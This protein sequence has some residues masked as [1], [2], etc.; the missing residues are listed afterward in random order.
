MR[1]NTRERLVARLAGWL[2]IPTRPGDFVKL[3]CW[4]RSVATSSG[5][6]ESMW[7]VLKQLDSTLDGA[8]IVGDAGERA[9]RLGEMTLD[10]FRAALE[11]SNELDPALGGTQIRSTDGR[12]SLLVEWARDEKAPLT[13]I[14]GTFSESYLDD[15]SNVA[16]VRDFSQA[17]ARAASVEY[18]LVSHISDESSKLRAS[19]EVAKKRGTRPIPRYEAKP[20][21][22][23]PYVPW[24]LVLGP[25]Y[26]NFFGRSQV[27]HLE[28]RESWWIGEHVGVV[29]APSPLDYGTSEVVEHERRIRSQLG[30]E[31]FFDPTAPDKVALGPDYAAPYKVW[32]QE[33]QERTVWDGYPSASGV[34]VVER[35]VGDE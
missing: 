20:A 10:G 26:V 33:G 16:R 25:Q 15:S 11:T 5:R 18:L 21:R 3:F 6:A 31:C 29:T 12:A 30:S 35:T 34:H 23:I 24:L 32:P 14:L 7:D 19:G 22:Y 2:S 17:L 9:N 1:P 27:D 13:T 28:G 8:L 4:S